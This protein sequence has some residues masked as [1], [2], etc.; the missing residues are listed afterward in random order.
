[1]TGRA[2]VRGARTDIY[3]LVW[4]NVYALELGATRSAREILA[5]VEASAKTTSPPELRSVERALEVAR[6]CRLVA[7]LRL[8]EPSGRCRATW[9]RKSW[10][11]RMSVAWL[12]ER[13]ARPAVAQNILHALEAAGWLRSEFRRAP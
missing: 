1:M 2:S 6:E 11:R 5:A 8:E 12:V 7:R 9:Q 13:G 3:R 10:P 4:A